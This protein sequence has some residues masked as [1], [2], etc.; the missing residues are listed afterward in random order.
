M[1]LQKILWD[2]FVSGKKPK[3]R[4]DIEGCLLQPELREPVEWYKERCDW[5]TRLR[6]AADHQ[7]D[8]WISKLQLW[9]L[10]K[11]IL[12]IDDYSYLANFKDHKDRINGCHS[13]PFGCSRNISNDNVSIKPRSTLIS[14]RSLPCPFILFNV[15][16]F[17]EGPLDWSSNAHSSLSLIFF[18]LF[19]PRVPRWSSN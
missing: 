13:V 1:C 8:R 15:F 6:A 7:I 17:V 10:G 11:N 14:S 2:S 12:P 18:S 19:L 4:H 16:R 5:R 3:D 9:I